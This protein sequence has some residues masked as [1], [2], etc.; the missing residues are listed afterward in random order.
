MSSSS[1]R[2]IVTVILLVAIGFFSIPFFS[3][4]TAKQVE[5]RVI[6]KLRRIPL[7]VNIKVVKTKKGDV[8]IGEKFPSEDDWFKQLTISVENTS[9]K[10]IIYIGGGFLFPNTENQEGGQAAPPLYHRFMYGH[11]PL[12]PV[13][14]LPP[15]SSI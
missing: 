5:D 7:P 13:D 2:Q 8:A 12:A 10:T 3:S 4:G 11:H 14:A 15:D 1:S 6:T 9:G